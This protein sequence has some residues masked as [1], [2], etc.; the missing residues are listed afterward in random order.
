MKSKKSILDQVAESNLKLITLQ[1]GVSST[2]CYLVFDQI[3]KKAIIVDPGDDAEFIKQRVSDLRLKPIAVIATHR[4]W[5]HTLAGEELGLIY[6]I[7]FSIGMP[8]YKLKL[9]DLKVIKA[10]D[11]TSES[12]CFYS[13]K[14]KF[15]LTG[16][17]SQ[18]K[19]KLPQDTIVYPGHGEKMPLEIATTMLKLINAK[20]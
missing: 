8:K 15:V 13:K 19:F 14:S 6:Q 20:N 5:D 1:V 10:G 18:I 4:H 11:H 16:D 9:G 7:P 2:N 3:N 12:I 17:I